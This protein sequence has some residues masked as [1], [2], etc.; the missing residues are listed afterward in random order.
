MVC[1]AAPS[2]I[3]DG[4]LLKE[5]EVCYKSTPDFKD[6][7]KKC[8]VNLE[9]RYKTAPKGKTGLAKFH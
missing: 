1:I 7:A 5:N 3:E 4:E 8:A 9:C 6:G 2:F